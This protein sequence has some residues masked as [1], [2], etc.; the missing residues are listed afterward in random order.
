MPR[1]KNAAQLAEEFNRK[2]R[3][4][5]DAEPVCDRTFQDAITIQTKALSEPRILEITQEAT[6]E[7]TAFA[8]LARQNQ[9]LLQ[10]QKRTR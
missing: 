4:R 8:H 3:L 10:I 6:P 1:R 9:T 5:P 7:E 2:C